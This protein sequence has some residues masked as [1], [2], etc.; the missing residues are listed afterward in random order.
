MEE[1][2]NETRY[3]ID[4]DEATDSSRSMSVI[5][6]GRKCYQDRQADTAESL[7]SSTAKQHIKRIA[8]HCAD[9]PDYAAQDT[10]LKEAIFREILA[11]GNEPKSAQEISEALST[12]WAVSPYPRDLSPTVIGRLLDHSQAYRITA[13]PEPEPEPEPES[14]PES[15]TEEMSEEGEVGAEQ[16]SATLEQVKE[17]PSEDAAKE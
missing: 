10:P 13:V 12:R 7:A 3:F 4:L 14:K 16:G 2:V 8:K 11:G 15:V 5:I 6:A 9:T 1:P 17:Q